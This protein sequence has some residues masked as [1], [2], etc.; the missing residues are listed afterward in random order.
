LAG[1]IVPFRLAVAR[2]RELHAAGC[3]L[4]PN[5]WDAGTARVLASLGF[6]ALA[7]TS[8]GMAFARGLP[9]DVCA[10][11][12]DAML[13]HVREIVAATSLPVNADFQAGYDGDPE[14]VAANVRLCIATGAA[15]LSI[16]DATG[17]RSAPLY[18][19]DEAVERV[20]AARA[21]VD[22]SGIPVVLHGPLRGL[23]RRS[24][25]ARAH[26]AA[27]PRRLRRGRRRLPLRPGVRDADTIAALVNAVAPRPR[28]TCSSPHPCPVSPCPASPSS[29]CAAS[30]WL[31]ARARCVERVPARRAP[32]SAGG[33]FDELASAAP[34]AELDRLFRA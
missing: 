4:L 1:W 23:A 25:G 19:D 6:S 29:A 30:R 27:P 34:F 20:R 12:R 24:P 13:A 22:A 28:S 8:A 31:G 18:P 5:P 21:A 10:V 15:G 17:E 7:T 14:G 32:L 11:S 16:E 2:F 9:D 3:F 33:S 26:R